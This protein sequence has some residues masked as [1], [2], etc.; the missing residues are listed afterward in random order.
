MRVMITGGTGFIGYHTARALTGAGHQV[1]LLVRNKD[2]LRRMYGS[3]ITDYVLGDVTDADAV[4]RALDGSD[5]VVHTAAM[6]S[7]D[8]KD[9]DVVMATNVGGTKLVIGGAVERGLGPIVHVSSVTALY[10]P[11]AQFLNEYSPLGAATNAYGR[12]KV[13]SEEF[14]RELQDGGAPIHI[15]YPASVIGPGDPGLTEPHQGLRTY[16]TAAAPVLPSGNQWVDVRDVAQAHLALLERELPP[17]RYPLGGHFLPW[18]ELVDVLSDITG[19]RIRKVPV[20]GG[21][22]LG[23]GRMVDWFN[24]VRGKALDIPVTHE[25]MTYATRWVR[26]DSSK[27][28]AELGLQFRPI[29]DTLADAIRDLVEEGHID[30]DKAGKLVEQ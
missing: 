18:G 1:R 27:A 25:A 7:I 3:D 26:M 8:Q 15:T 23:M 6:V 29:Q 22:M 19:R 11:E 9:A 14:V 30:A 20:P 24:R 21:V 16:L 10:D 12:S 13:A 2:K 5:A 28:R 17:G 4:A